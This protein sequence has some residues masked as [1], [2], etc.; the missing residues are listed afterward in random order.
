MAEEPFL[1]FKQ[2][3][4]ELNLYYHQIQRAAKKGYIPTYSPFGRRKLVRLSEVVA[5]VEASKVGGQ[6]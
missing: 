4:G 1:T 2:A 6:K 3:A 5:F